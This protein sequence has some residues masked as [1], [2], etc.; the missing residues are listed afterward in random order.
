VR[1]RRTH[2]ARTQHAHSTRAEVFPTPP[3]LLA[4]HPG[5]SRQRRSTL[6]TPPRG[7]QVTTNIQE[8]Y[9]IEMPEDTKNFLDAIKGIVSFD[10]TQTF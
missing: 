3:S 2:T 6:S 5:V 4:R 10:V 8:V 7:A 9:S 1:E